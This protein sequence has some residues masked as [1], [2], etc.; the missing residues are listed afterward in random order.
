MLKFAAATST[1][2]INIPN[3][4]AIVPIIIKVFFVVKISRSKKIFSMIQT[5]NIIIENLV[6]VS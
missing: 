2:M 6:I 5:I 4:Y 1:K 3:I